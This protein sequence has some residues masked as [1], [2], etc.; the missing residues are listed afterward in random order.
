MIQSDKVRAARKASQRD[1]IKAKE[2]LEGQARAEWFAA[3][4]KQQAKA[5][6]NEQIRAARQGLRDA[7]DALQIAEETGENLLA[8]QE[9]AQVAQ[10]FVGKLVA[11]KVVGSTVSLTSAG[12][13]A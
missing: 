3:L 13:A 7:I 11:S 10:M 1:R 9:N 12:G 6:V 4:P 5:K 2:E 8:A